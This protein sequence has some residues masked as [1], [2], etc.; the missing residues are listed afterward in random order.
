[1]NISNPHEDDKTKSKNIYIDLDTL[2][3]LYNTFEADLK[4]NGGFYKDFIKSN[5]SIHN[6]YNKI[7]KGIWNVI[8]QK[9]ARNTALQHGG[10]E[11]A[12]LLSGLSSSFSIASLLALLIYLFFKKDQCK[13]VYPV[14][15]RNQI[16]S[17]G[18]IVSHYLPMSWIESME[19]N[20]IRAIDFFDTSM[21]RLKNLENVFSIFDES[22]GSPLKDITTTVV[23]VG[24]SIGADIVSGATVGSNIVNFPFMINKC[25]KFVTT[26]CSK[27]SSIIDT[28]KPIL[29][30]GLDVLTQVNASLDMADDL[31]SKAHSPE[32]AKMFKQAHTQVRFLCDISMINFRDGPE[33]CKCWVNY[34]FN[35]Y[36]KEID[37]QDGSALFCLAND[38]YTTING[39]MIDFIGSALDSVIPNTMGL[40]G[41]FSRL[42]EGYSYEIYKSILK[43]LT[44]EY[45]KIPSTYRD[46]IQHPENFSTFIFNLSDKYAFDAPSTIMTD[47]FKEHIK[48][49]LDIVAYATHKCISITWVLLNVFIIFAELNAGKSKLDPKKHF[50][51]DGIDKMCAHEPVEGNT[52]GNDETTNVNTN[53]NT[54]VEVNTAG[55]DNANNTDK[56]SNGAPTNESVEVNT[57]NN[58]DN[59]S[60]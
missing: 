16:P 22:S 20:E 40:I 38:I 2:D 37:D 23:K 33:Q 35:L 25:I 36:F 26:L 27:V 3:V 53:V 24:A 46:L 5:K 10:F 17:I 44:R 8:R 52:V 41:T 51:K 47:E 43:E 34:V 7:Y 54:N 57:A 42:L 1:M 45:Y 56:T 21:A 14:Y 59:D 32:T 55:N 29:M 11:T 58:N 50:D 9:N 6:S 18:E 60:A 15:D 48:T 31:I 28:L 4:K 12:F 30:E 19:S 39:L 49:G 13:K